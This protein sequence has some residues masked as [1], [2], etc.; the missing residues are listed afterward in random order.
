M[1]IMGIPLPLFV[2]A[3]LAAVGV[4]TFVRGRQIHSE[5][6]ARGYT[7]YSGDIARQRLVLAGVAA[8]GLAIVFS[9]ALLVRGITAGTLSVPSGELLSGTED[10]AATSNEM[11]LY[12]GT[13]GLGA[14]PIIELR[15][16]D[17]TWSVNDLDTE[18]GHLQGTAY[19]G[20]TGNVVLTGHV[21]IPNAGWGP[22][23]ELETIEEGAEVILLYGGKE[24]IYKVA[25]KMSVE[26][27][28]V[29]YVLPTATPR[30]TLITCTDETEEGEYRRRLIVIA[31]LADVK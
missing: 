8:V 18:I 4:V 27:T 29:D 2:V 7:N 6:H 1:S 26:P 11:K 20:D 19:P 9:G 12:I 24:Y 21:T 5:R 17:E 30:L 10:P 28:N 13:L 22:F 23:S 15:M 16:I 3:I 31:E 25:A 14:V